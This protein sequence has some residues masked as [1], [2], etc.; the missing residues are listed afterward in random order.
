[1]IV[2]P[3]H[4]FGGKSALENDPAPP[5]QKQVISGVHTPGVKSQRGRYKKLLW[6]PK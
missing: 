2:R 3:K 5:E 1:M 4:E 6:F